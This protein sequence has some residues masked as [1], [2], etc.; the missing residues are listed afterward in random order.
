ME[1]SLKN[2][3]IVYIKQYVMEI[4]DL[5]ETVNGFYSRFLNGNSSPRGNSIKSSVLPDCKLYVNVKV[6]LLSDRRD[7]CFIGL[8][9]IKDFYGQIIN[10][11]KSYKTPH[12]GIS[13]VMLVFSS[14]KASSKK[15]LRKKQNNN[16]RSFLKRVV[17]N[18]KS[19][20]QWTNSSLLP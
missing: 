16:T 6:M 20:A 15:L 3:W 11:F 5:T 7:H 18:L 4:F 12:I 13:S 1:E 10:R 14:V 19:S 9:V 17:K 8:T 2:S